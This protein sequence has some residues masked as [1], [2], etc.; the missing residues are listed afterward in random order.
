ME[1]SDLLR[2]REGVARRVRH[3]RRD[4]APLLERARAVGGGHERARDGWLPRRVPAAAAGVLRPAQR[5]ALSW[6]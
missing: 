1:F 3:L 6:I 5:P 2:T 4:F